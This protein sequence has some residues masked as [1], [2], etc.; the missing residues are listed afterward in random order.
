MNIWD[1]ILQGIVQGL[2]EFLPVSSSGHLSLVQHFSGFSGEMGLMF[3][4]LLHCGTLAAVFVAFWR[5]IWGLIAELGLSVADIFRGR[6]TF[7]NMA[8]RRRMLVMVIVSL[9]PLIPA[10]FVSEYYEALACDGDILVE[11]I[12]FLITAALLFISGKCQRGEKTAGNMSYS[13]ALIVG[14]TQAFLAPLPGVSRSG[15]TI[16]AGMMRGLTREDAVA[17]SFIIGIPPVL[18]SNLLN[19]PDAVRA[20]ADVGAGVLLAGMA[21][22]AVV[23][24]LAIKLVRWLV[25]TDKFV[26]FAWY[27]AILGA[28]TVI[29]AIYEKINGQTVFEM[30]SR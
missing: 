30:L 20:G 21:V 3:T 5:Q 11:G 26:W 18:A 17:F 22:S 14:A 4:I 2:T 23:G 28:L 6:F 25:K 10:Y 13:D 9:F 7:K 24:F 29:V 19:I 15:S 27:T 12:C 1:A 16:S 8:P